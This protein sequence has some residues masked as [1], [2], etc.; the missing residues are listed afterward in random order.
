[1]YS[2][3]CE[4]NALS[5]HEA[6]PRLFTKTSL[7]NMPLKKIVR[8]SALDKTARRMPTAY[9]TIISVKRHEYPAIVWQL[10]VVVPNAQQSHV[11]THQHS[12]T[13]VVVA[14]FVTT[15][16]SIPVVGVYMAP[17]CLD[18]MYSFYKLPL[19]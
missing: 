9:F 1:M 17:T 16:H 14:V 15:T 4:G 13:Y 12:L 7:S 6:A 3:T 10:R 5:T 18:A 11:D 19:F 8:K 2:R